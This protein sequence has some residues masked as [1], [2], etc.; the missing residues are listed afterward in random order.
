MAPPTTL[1]ET[2]WPHAHPDPLPAG[3]GGSSGAWVITVVLAVLS[4]AFEQGGESDRL[5]IILAVVGILLPV[6]VETR[7]RVEELANRLRNELAAEADVNALRAERLTSAQDEFKTLLQQYTAF[8]QAPASARAFLA[9]AAADWQRL[10]EHASV[11]LGW[12]RYQHD[13]IELYPALAQ[14]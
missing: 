3:G 10:D 11:F 8:A 5:A 6:V 7:F 2:P 9:E 12:L 1:R 14:G 4:I 13:V